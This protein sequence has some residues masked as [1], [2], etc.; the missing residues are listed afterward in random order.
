MPSSSKH[1]QAP[2]TLPNIGSDYLLH[3]A[4]NEGSIERAAL[5]LSRKAS[6]ACIDRPDPQGWTPL[7]HGTW[8][9]SSSVV[10]LLLS[11]GAS[12][13]AVDVDGFSA[14]LLSIQ[15]RHLAVT[16]MLLTAGAD[17]E[18]KTASCGSTSLH[19]AVSSMQPEAVRVLIEAGANPDSR[20]SDGPTPIL[21]AAYNGAVACI[22]ELLRG[23]ADPTLGMTRATPYNDAPFIPLDAAAQ[24]RHLE[25]VRELLQRVGIEGCGGAT[26]GENALDLAGRQECLEI[27]ATLTDAGVVDRNGS[28]LR[29]AIGCGCEASAKFLLRQQEGATGRYVS[30]RH[31]D[32]TTP[33]F[34]CFPLATA[35][36]CFPRMVRLLVDAGADTTSPIAIEHQGSS[37]TPLEFVSHYLVEGFSGPF[38]EEQSNRLKAARRV[39]LQAEAVHAVSWLW[40]NAPSPTDHAAADKNVQGT[41]T[42]S[43]ALTTTLPNLRRRAA[44]QKISLLAPL[45]R[46]GVRTWNVVGGVAD[47][48]CID[49]SLLAVVGTA[50][51]Q[52]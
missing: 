13:S 50:V 14:L 47:A 20:S 25:A 43:S 23:K 2:W 30:R 7:M 16:K 24:N 38:T 42:I 35:V 17:K 18:A 6:V 27:M 45:F 39:L 10:R 26:R 31:R 4:A 48:F 34:F 41:E 9:G 29:G 32:G 19:L 49:P 22:R 5:L 3:K 52:L 1:V 33:L 15:R 28:A 11:N 12:V 8:R 36:G 21:L 46:W 37:A 44:R 40:V 51:L